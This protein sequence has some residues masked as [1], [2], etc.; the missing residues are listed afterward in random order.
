M[1]RVRRPIA[2]ITGV[3]T[4]GGQAGKRVGQRVASGSDPGRLVTVTGRDPEGG[5]LVSFEEHPGHREVGGRITGGQVAEVDDCT[6]S[7]VNGQQVGGV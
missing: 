3:V 7:A 4:R 6:E 1:S 5:P 2:A